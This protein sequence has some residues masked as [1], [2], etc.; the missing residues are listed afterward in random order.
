[1]GTYNNDPDEFFGGRAFGGPM[2]DRLSADVTPLDID[3]TVDWSSV[4]GLESHIRSLKEMIALPMMYPEL[5]TKFHVSPP[6][7]V[8]FF[9]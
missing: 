5:F 8:L 4:G 2:H 9:G 7:G 6:K 1:M 3:T